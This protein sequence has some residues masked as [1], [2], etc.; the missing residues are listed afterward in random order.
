[1]VTYGKGWEKVDRHIACTGQSFTELIFFEG[2]LKKIL[3]WLFTVGKELSAG[4]NNFL[5]E[6][7]ILGE[8]DKKSWKKKYFWDLE[9]SAKSQKNILERNFF[10]Y[11]TSRR[12]GT[13]AECGCERGLVLLLDI[14]DF[15]PLITTAPAAD[16]HE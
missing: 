9:I 6:V 11:L 8:T 14:A 1:M 5:A 3:N 2:S 4:V 16:L 15:A 13:S 12:F 7:L 10:S